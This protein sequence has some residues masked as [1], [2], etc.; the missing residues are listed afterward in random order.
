MTASFNSIEVFGN[1]LKINYV[2]GSADIAYPASTELYIVKNNSQVIITPT[3]PTPPIPGSSWVR[4]VDAQFGI[5]SPFGPRPSPGGIGSTNHLGVDFSGS[6][7]IDKPIYAASAGIVIAIGTQPTPGRGFGYSCAILHE[8]GSRTM[9]GHQIRIPNLDINQSVT[10]GQIIGHIG[11]T[12]ASTGA[13]LHFET[14][15]SKTSYPVDPVPFMK[16][17]GI[18]L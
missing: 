10:V 18:T 7:V 17:R 15:N 16:L 13:H 11:S 8:D 9:Y 3:T 6:G 4:P 12:G 1:Q 5:V 14:R 2:D